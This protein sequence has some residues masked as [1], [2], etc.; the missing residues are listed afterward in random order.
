M[1]RDRTPEDPSSSTSCHDKNQGHPHRHECLSTALTPAKGSRG[2]GGYYRPLHWRGRKRGKRE[3]EEEEVHVI[4][5]WEGVGHV[6]SLIGVVGSGVVGFFGCEGVGLCRPPLN[7]GGNRW[8]AGVCFS[9]S[10]FPSETDGS[11]QLKQ[12]GHQEVVQAEHMAAHESIRTAISRNKM[13]SCGS[14]GQCA[15]SKQGT[16]QLNYSATAVQHTFQRTCLC[17]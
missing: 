3:E 4:V 5:S 15:L 11:L 14:A 2:W 10:L 13:V 8:T 12:P 1:Q 17:S 9:V 6:M 16:L 7:Q